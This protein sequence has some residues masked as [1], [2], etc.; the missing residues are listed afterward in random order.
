MVFQS[1]AS[2]E[3]H[4][5]HHG[6][7]GPDFLQ[8]RHTVPLGK[9]QIKNQEAIASLSERLKRTLS[10]VHDIDA[11]FFALKASAKKVREWN[12]VFCNQKT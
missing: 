5:R 9:I 6:G 12:I 4:D 3:H 10:I 1:T 2:G 7:L 8:N 11:T